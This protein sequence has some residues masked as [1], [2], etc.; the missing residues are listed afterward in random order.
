MKISTN[1]KKKPNEYIKRQKKNISIKKK[2]DKR[3]IV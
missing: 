3:S 1:E 2:K